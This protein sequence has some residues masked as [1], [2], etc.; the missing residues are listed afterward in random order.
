VIDGTGEIQPLFSIY[1]PAILARPDVGS[2]EGAASDLP[3]ARDVIETGRFE[4]IAIPE[5]LETALR[6]VDTPADFELLRGGSAS[7]PSS[8]S[9]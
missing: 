1:T 5:D 2:N 8:S 7:N 9:I 3:S 4:R 6:S